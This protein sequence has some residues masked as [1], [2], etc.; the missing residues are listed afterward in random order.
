MTRNR[1]PIPRDPNEER[2][3]RGRRDGLLDAQCWC[4][5]DIV[6]VDPKDLQAG[7]TGACRRLGCSAPIGGRQ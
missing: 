7:L 4:Q 1:T 6:P 5:R 2:A 3:P